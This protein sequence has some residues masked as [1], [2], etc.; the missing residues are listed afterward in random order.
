MLINFSEKKMEK[1]RNHPKGLKTLYQHQNT[2]GI[3]SF[4]KYY[5]SNFQKCQIYIL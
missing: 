4:L 5:M 1:E 3:I 2:L